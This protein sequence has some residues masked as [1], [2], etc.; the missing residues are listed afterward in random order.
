[1]KPIDFGL[2]RKSLRGEED[3][4]RGVADTDGMTKSTL[5]SVG[6]DDRSVSL[7]FSNR[8]DKIRIFITIK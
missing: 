3:L 7:R 5:K 2:R 6:G 1:M 4:E 8:E